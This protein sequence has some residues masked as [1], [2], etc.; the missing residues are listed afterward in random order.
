MNGLLLGSVAVLLLLSPEIIAAAE[1][2]LDSPRDYQIVQRSSRG[3]A[4][5]RIAGTISED[6]EAAQAAVE[7]RLT[8]AGK[9]A[10]WRRIGGLAKGRDF[11]GTLI[12]PAG[13]WWTLE[14]RIP[15]GGG[16]VATGSVAHVGIGEVFVVAGQ[17]NSANHGEERQRPR[18]GR[19]STFD[20]T[21][22]RL[23]DDPQPGASGNGGSFLPAFGDAVAVSQDVPVG[24]VACGIGATSVR[25]WLPKGFS[26]PNAP[27]LTDRAV[28]L[29]NGSWASN[30]MAFDAFVDRMK[31]FGPGGFRAVLWH[32][33]ESDANQQD[34]TRTLPGALYRRYLE[35]LIR[36]SERAIGW[37]P[38][39]F[40]AQASYHAPG[41]EGSDDIRAAQASLWKDAVALE[42]PD[43]DALKGPLREGGGRGVHFSA[44]GLREHG[45]RWAEKVIYWL[46]KQQAEP[47]Q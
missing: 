8:R 20:G 47:R 44:A 32:Q 40:V 11:T 45:Y 35:I 1:M 24:I 17:S 18:T 38:P 21:T 3:D 39:W 14:V 22:W 33:G 42:G 29:S 43:T 12:A 16:R 13:G 9:E 41:D 31:P 6:P 23:A 10:P 34:P 46:E 15:L 5:V 2:R 28:P 19:V 30:G 27:T 4:A 36:E 37:D 7:A 25:E 26:F